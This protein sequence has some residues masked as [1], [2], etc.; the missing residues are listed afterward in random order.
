M[1][2]EKN[3]INELKER[4]KYLRDSQI[5]IAEAF[6]TE[7][8]EEYVSTNRAAEEEVIRLSDEAEKCQRQLEEL[9][10]EVW[11]K[12]NGYNRIG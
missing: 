9:E 2:E 10:F 5:K 11:C 3:K 8:D 6:G 12:E 4:I 1:K 7:I